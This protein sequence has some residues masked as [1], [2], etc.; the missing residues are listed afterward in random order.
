MVPD[1]RAA[2]EGMGRV[3]T[4]FPPATFERRSKI[5]GEDEGIVPALIPVGTIDEEVERF[6]AD[7]DSV[8]PGG[9]IRIFEGETDPA[10]WNDP[11]VIEA[12]QRAAE[13]ARMLV[14]HYNRGTVMLL[15][16]RHEDALYDLRYVE[17]LVNRLS[18]TPESIDTKVEDETTQTFRELLGNA[19]NNY[20]YTLLQL[21]RA[22]QA[23]P[24]LEQ[25]LEFNPDVYNA[26]N[27]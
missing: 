10:F 22:E 3:F 9:K 25:A 14:E 24:Y 5:I 20:G 15:A 18:L 1:L 26:S 17:F 19:F 12:S 4:P 11:R 27:N 23:L 8:K 7:V 6:V 21:G 2:I 16:G 13:P